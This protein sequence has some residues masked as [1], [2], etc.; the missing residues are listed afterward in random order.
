[1]SDTADHDLMGNSLR[2]SWR[3]VRSSVMTAES[4][5]GSVKLP[6]SSGASGVLG[7]DSRSRTHRGRLTGSRGIGCD[8]GARGWIM[9]DPRG[10]WPELVS[11]GASGEAVGR[12]NEEKVGVTA[13]IV[14][15]RPS[16]GTC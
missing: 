15:S 5:H 3:I 6:G 9:C 12:L 10:T 7:G 11:R 1:M 13:G 4:I 16:Q 2:S 8:K 14:T